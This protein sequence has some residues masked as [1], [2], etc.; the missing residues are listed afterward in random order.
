[1]FKNLLNFSYRRNVKEAIG[2]YIAY[3][4]ISALGTIVI[5]AILSLATG[6]E[7]DV[8]FHLRIAIIIAIITTLSLSFLILKS[9]NL[10]GNFFYIILLLLSVLLLVYFGGVFLGLI[11][12]SFLST[13]QGR[14][15]R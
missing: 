1:M 3:V 8:E 10:L 15:E 11:P 7:S 14:D 4:V 6:N 2:F 5:S 12:V 9:K 13:R